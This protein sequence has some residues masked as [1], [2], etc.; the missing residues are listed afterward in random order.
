MLHFSICFPSPQILTSFPKLRP[1]PD[2]ALK[3][4]ADPQTWIHSLPPTQPSPAITSLNIVTF[5]LSSQAFTHTLDF[6]RLSKMQICFETWFLTFFIGFH[7]YCL[8]VT[9]DQTCSVYREGEGKNK[10]GKVNASSRVRLLSCLPQKSLQGKVCIYLKK[11]TAALQSLHRT[12]RV[13]IQSK[14]SM[15]LLKSLDLI[16][17]SQRTDSVEMKIRHS[18][19]SLCFKFR[20]PKS[21]LSSLSDSLTETSS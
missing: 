10:T 3:C 15:L 6:Y 7:A 8:W 20:G 13:K 5:A 12:S 17:Q 14:L 19:K 21:Y 18:P 11:I 16:Q 2:E 1:S 9:P 4:H